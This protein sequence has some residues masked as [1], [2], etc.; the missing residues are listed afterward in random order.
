MMAL[1]VGVVVRVLGEC[2]VYAFCAAGKCHSSVAIA[3]LDGGEL[4]EL[5][6]PAILFDGQVV[7]PAVVP[8]GVV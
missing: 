5:R 3:K 2:E 7:A 8:T 4:L 1:F 6:G